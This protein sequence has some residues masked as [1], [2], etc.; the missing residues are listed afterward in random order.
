MTSRDERREAAVGP[1]GVPPGLAGLMLPRVV[2]RAI[3]HELAHILLNTRTHTRHGL[4]RSGFT[5]DDFVSPVRDGF[6]LDRTQIAL[7]HRHQML[8]APDQ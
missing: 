8:L 7:A 4:L 6:T 3:A 2:G 5:A 1:V